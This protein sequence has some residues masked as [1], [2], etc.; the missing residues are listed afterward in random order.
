MLNLPLNPFKLILKLLLILTESEVSRSFEAFLWAHHSGPAQQGPRWYL[1]SS[2]PQTASKLIIFM[3]LTSLPTKHGILSSLFHEYPSSVWFSFC[4]FIRYRLGMT[5]LMLCMRNDNHAAGTEE[6]AW[7]PR[8]CVLRPVSGNQTPPRLLRILKRPLEEQHLQS[9]AA[10]PLRAASALICAAID[11]PGPKAQRHKTQ[12]NFLTNCSPETA[13]DNIIKPLCLKISTRLQFKDGS[14]GRI[15]W[16]NHKWELVKKWCHNGNKAGLFP[17][18]TMVPLI[19]QLCVRWR[20]QDACE[21]LSLSLPR[22]YSPF[23]TFVELCSL[24]PS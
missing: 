5:F 24:I 3:T 13:M 18:N 21:M 12:P 17:T 9:P 14:V 4:C 20:L 23:G 6:T 7:H 22:F 2:S 15:L 10:L 16:E 8:A 19:Q 1:C 11:T